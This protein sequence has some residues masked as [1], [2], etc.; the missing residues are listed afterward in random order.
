[1]KNTR[2][3]TKWCSKCSVETRRVLLG[4][5][6]WDNIYLYHKMKQC[7]AAA[8]YEYTQPVQYTQ[9]GA[10]PQ[11]SQ[12]Q[13]PATQY[14]QTT[15]PVQQFSQQPAPQMFA[16]PQQVVYVNQINRKAKFRGLSSSNRSFVVLTLHFILRRS[17]HI[18][19]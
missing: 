18:R 8:T 2:N 9:P 17:E 5:S 12:Y 3:A 6:R 10:I 7:H 4:F 13:Q 19:I 1:M 14:M 11:P 16:A 15:Q